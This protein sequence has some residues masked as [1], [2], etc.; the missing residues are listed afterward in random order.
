MRRIA[1]EEVRTTRPDGRLQLNVVLV[2]AVMEICGKLHQFLVKRHD[3]E[4]AE[5]TA[6]G[7]HGCRFTF[8]AMGNVVHVIDRQRRDIPLDRLLLEGRKKFEGVIVER[9]ALQQIVKN[10]IRIKED[11]LLATDA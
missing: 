6:H 8:Q 3:I 2:I 9:F 10:H 4:D 5:N 1:G 7:N 11:A